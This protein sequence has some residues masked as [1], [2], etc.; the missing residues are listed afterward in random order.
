M[1]YRLGWVLYWLCLAIAGGWSA[2]VIW[3]S[4][5]PGG[6]EDIRQSPYLVLVMAIP[7][8]VAYGLGRAFR[9]VLSGK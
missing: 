2:F 5:E 6:F 9:Y 7:V 1:A 4:M 8:L 3:V